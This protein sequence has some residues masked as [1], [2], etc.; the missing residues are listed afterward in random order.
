VEAVTRLLIVGAG[1]GRIERVLTM[2]AATRRTATYQIEAEAG[3]V[4]VLLTHK[5]FSDG[6]ETIYDDIEVLVED[7]PTGT[8]SHFWGAITSDALRIFYDLITLTREAEDLTHTDGPVVGWV[9]GAPVAPTEGA[10]RGGWVP[11]ALNY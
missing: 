10:T 1:G 2:P 5:N 11:S 6:T 8:H 7:M 3:V 9:M 4:R